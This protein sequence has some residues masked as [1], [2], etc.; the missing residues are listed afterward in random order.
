MEKS[1]HYLENTEI[2]KLFLNAGRYRKS[3]TTLLRL[4]HPGEVGQTLITYVK[5]GDSIRQESQSEI[6]GDDIIARNAE[7]IGLSQS[8]QSLYNEWPVNEQ[9]IIKNYGEAA[10][11]SLT[12]E[13]TAHK[14]QA[15]LKA[16]E[17]TQGVLNALDV[18]GDTLAIP[19]S[20]SE[21]P[22]LAKLGDF[23]TSE[24]YSISAHDMKSYEP[25]E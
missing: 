16:I 11:R 23:I 14:K 15:T 19:V 3:A 8:N 4:P 21:T 1:I 9:T 7:I 20:W 12:H 17:L 22:M 13:F 5:D 6:K 10:H 24:G 18:Q 2:Q 25:A